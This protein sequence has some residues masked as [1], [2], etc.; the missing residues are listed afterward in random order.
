[1]PKY[2][3]KYK[4][5]A[6]DLAKK[7]DELRAKRLMPAGMVQMDEAERVMTLEQL[8]STKRELQSILQGLPISM[9]SEGLRQ[10]KRDLE[11]RLDDV[12]R[13]ITTF[14]RKV[15]YI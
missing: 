13:N 10:K 6:V 15:V 9:R 7:R 8:Q 5:E 1:M 12:E 4:E 11:Q 2:I 3:E 14:S